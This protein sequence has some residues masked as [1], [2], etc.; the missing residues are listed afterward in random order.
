MGTSWKLKLAT[1]II[2]VG[3]FV[4]AAPSALAD[5]S[6]GICVEKVEQIASP[7]SYSN[8]NYTLSIRGTFPNDG[9]GIWIFAQDSSG[10]Y[11]AQ[12]G[13]GIRKR[14]NSPTIDATRRFGVSN[15]SGYPLVFSV[16]KTG[17][18]GMT[19]YSTTQRRSGRVS[20]PGNPG[21]LYNESEVGTN[22]LTGSTGCFVDLNANDRP[23][24]SECSC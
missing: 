11:Y 5:M 20:R 9:D 14:G 6:V 4:V 18:N 21:H 12:Q 2:C 8:F 7:N 1:S 22:R 17:A 24:F 3:S 16:V 23:D 10:A 15:S 19:D 13:G